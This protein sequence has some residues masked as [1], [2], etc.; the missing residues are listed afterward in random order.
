MDALFF[1][2]LQEAYEMSISF[3]THEF[4][5]E[6]LDIE[7]PKERSESSKRTKEAKAAIL[8]DPVVMQRAREV[9]SYDIRLY[10]YGNYS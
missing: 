4:H 6:K 9:N 2:G 5:I 10:E 1:A 8:A 3:L 7:L